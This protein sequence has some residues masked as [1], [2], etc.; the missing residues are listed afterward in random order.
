MGNKIRWGIVGTGLIAHHFANGLKAVDD[1]D[2]VAVA[3]RSHDAA[4]KFAEEFNIP[5]KH[6]GIDKLVANL[7]VDVIYIG[8]PHTSHFA[9][10]MTCLDAGKAVLCEKP[11]TINV[12]ELQPLIAKAREKKAFLMEAMWTRFFPAMK[13]VRELI[14]AGAIGEIRLLQSNFCFKCPRDLDWRLLN[15]DLGGGALLD[16]GVY[17][18]ALANMIFGQPPTRIVSSAHRGETGVDEL[19]SIILNYDNGAMATSSCSLEIITPSVAHIYGTEG[20]IEILD[21][22]WQ[23]EKL[24][25]TPNNGDSETFTFESTGNGYNYEAQAVMQCLRDGQTESPLMTLDES[26]EIMTTMDTIRK[27]WDFTYPMEK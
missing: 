22:Y 21:P 10:T 23:P 20:H 11:F 5:Q 24:T 6:V 19:S 26:L 2:L 25:L 4:D 15:P 9:D 16:I 27:Q 8:T 18:I 14:S 17:N 3:S 13:K 12:G 1:A 7:E